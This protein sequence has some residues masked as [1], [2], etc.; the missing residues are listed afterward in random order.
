[1]SF[2]DTLRDRL[3]RWMDSDWSANDHGGVGL[4]PGG[5][6]H[7][8]SAVEEMAA[9]A[10]AESDRPEQEREQEKSGTE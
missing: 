9:D 3:H 8:P 2:R 6:L 10:A 1:M 5:S 7:T 4:G